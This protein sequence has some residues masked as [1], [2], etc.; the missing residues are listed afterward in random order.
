MIAESEL[1]D[2]ANNPQ[3][4]IRV[5]EC[6]TNALKVY[7]KYGGAIFEGYATYIDKNN[8]I[9]TTTH[10][11]NLVKSNT[12]QKLD[13]IIDIANYLANTGV[14]YSNHSGTEC[15]IAFIEGLAKQREHDRYFFDKFVKTHIS[16]E[17][18]NE[19][20]AH[21][22]ILEVGKVK[23]D[24]IPFNPKAIQLTAAA[25]GLST[26]LVAYQSFSIGME[27]YK[28][29][30]YVWGAVVTVGIKFTAPRVPLSEAMLCIVLALALNYLCGFLFSSVSPFF[31]FV[32]GVA[33]EALCV[34]G[35]G[36][37]WVRKG[38]I[39]PWANRW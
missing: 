39:P 36:A 5:G 19:K 35:F 4:D 6:D 23:M 2:F 33:I 28:Y 20:P 16:F 25:I 3:N 10:Y 7:K 9:K 24:Q 12:P 11:W 18:T 26:A 31:Y 22:Q 38:Y 27:V 14:V 13:Q 34:L 15:S 21:Y 17:K 32:E 30:P 1:R 37:R 29:L 8:V